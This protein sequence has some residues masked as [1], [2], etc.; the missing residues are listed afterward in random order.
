MTH[1]GAPASAGVH[2]PQNENSPTPYGLLKLVSSS[3]TQHSPHLNVMDEKPAF[4]CTGRSKCI[5]R[6][7]FGHK[8]GT[9]L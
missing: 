4:R 6:P 9:S 1:P 8:G 5:G 3:V 2:G 7:Q